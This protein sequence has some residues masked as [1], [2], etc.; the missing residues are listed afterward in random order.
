MTNRIALV[1]LLLARISCE[2][3]AQR[4][5]ADTARR[6]T[7]P[8]APIVVTATRT[9]EP[10]SILGNSVSVLGGEELLKAG[11]TSVSDA[12]RVLAGAT[13]VEQSGPGS[14]TSLFLRGG[15]SNYVR[16]L[17]DGVP[18]N[19]AGGSIDLANLTTA[20][21]ER[22]EL[23]RGP[24]SVTYGSDAVTGVLQI[25]TR[26]TPG[27]VRFNLAARGGTFESRDAVGEL[28]AGSERAGISIGGGHTSTDGFYAFNND[29]RNSTET[30]SAWWQPDQRTDLRLT[31]RYNDARYNF[32]TEGSGT[33]TDSNQYQ[34]A[35]IT[36][37]GFDAGR[38]LTSAL[39]VR[40]LFG[41]HESKDG[42]DDHPDNP[43][44]TIFG[45]FHSDVVTDRKSG[46]LRLNYRAGGAVYT[47]GAVLD[48]ERG[49]G[50]TSFGGSP[51]LERTNRA[52]YGQLLRAWAGGASLQAGLRVE[53]NEAFGSHVTWRAGGALRLGPETRLRLNAGT[54]FKEPTFLQNFNSA[55]STGNPDL[56]PERSTSVEA[57][58]EHRFAAA[59]ATVSAT[60]FMQ[61]FRDMIQYSPASAP[62]APSYYNIAGATASGL[63]TELSWRPGAGLHVRAEYTL[64][65]TS[66]QDSGFDG[67]QFAPGER[68]IR[69]PTNSGSLSL[70]FAPPGR[71]SVGGRWLLVGTRDDLDFNAFPA[72]RVTLPGYG[73][74]DL[75]G[76]VQLVRRRTGVALTAKVE[77][78]LDQP[79]QEVYGFPTPG[80]RLL[81]GARVMTTGQ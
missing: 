74:L 68:L 5:P 24:G 72:S 40:A 13:V 53:D 27:P 46:D 31:A 42:Y 6:D 59:R 21:V 8:L 28:T 54:A 55:F 67:Q 20:N 49:R 37:V 57:G 1:L 15:Q 78:V 61:W 10:V 32:P 75:W 16:V 38:R 26:R 62:P 43:G 14:V 30:G 56:D 19:E 33:P 34:T 23:V 52:V 69:R 18:I 39:E 64:L 17:V 45:T 7:T 71:A 66:V 35:R 2:A 79:Y 73:R 80:Q 41:F 70:D 65:L 22:I 51:A 63:E 50:W 44:D 58:L 12:L 4:V 47:L 36:T 25:I 11:I 60:A 48:A 81:V 29:Y 9:P 77:N 3:A 76:E